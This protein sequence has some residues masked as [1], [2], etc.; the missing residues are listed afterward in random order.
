MA[1]YYCK[2]CGQRFSSVSA[3]TMNKCIR[4]PAGPNKGPHELYEG[5]EKSRYTCK[6]C[7]QSFSSIQ[8]MTMN[9]CY[10]HPN[11]PNKGSHSP[12]L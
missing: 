9:K 8:A 12:A 6:Y 5:S 7:G 4:H 10:R 11:G 3:L 1:N 2:N